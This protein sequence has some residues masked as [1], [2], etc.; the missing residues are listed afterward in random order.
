MLGTVKWFNAT[1]GYGFIDGDDKEKYFV[2]FS[3][4]SSDGFKDLNEGQ[5]VE[6]AP[7]KNAKGLCADKVSVI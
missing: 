7:G 2:H 1:K 6:F 3:M 4:I 5:R